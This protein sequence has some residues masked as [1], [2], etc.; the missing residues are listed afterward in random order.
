M[1]RA[2]GSYRCS[3]KPTDTYLCNGRYDV[4]YVH[5]DDYYMD[6]ARL[7]RG[8]TT[9][10]GRPGEL[11]P[12]EVSWR[13][14]RSANPR[15]PVLLYQGGSILSDFP[16][17]WKKTTKFKFCIS[18]ELGLTWESLPTIHKVCP[19]GNRMKQIYRPG[20]SDRND[21]TDR[22][23]F[24]ARHTPRCRDHLGMRLGH[25]SGQICIRWV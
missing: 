22:P 17:C 2:F 5:Y 18:E 15:S 21:H 8:Y 7:F 12:G 6:K 23:F 4:T 11:N 24:S 14:L 10:A 20:S 1:V 19:P 16:R 13:V 25:P 3:R 9:G